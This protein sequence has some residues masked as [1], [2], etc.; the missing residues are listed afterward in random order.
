MAS[1]FNLSRNTVLYAAT[2]DGT[3]AGKSET[4]AYSTTNA[5]RI[6]VLDGYAFSQDVET[7]V[8]GLNEAG[9]RPV[10]GQKI[11][12]TALNPVDVSFTTYMRPFDNAASHD[13]I[14]RV[15]WEAIATGPS[16]GTNKS[17]TDVFA[18]DNSAT[19]SDTN[20]LRVDF[21][22]SNVHELLHLYL[23]FEL[24]NGKGFR[25]DKVILNTA[26]I[27]FSIDD[28]A[29]VTW[30]GQG[31]S[32][33]E[34]S[35]TTVAADWPTSTFFTDDNASGLFIK[36]KLST[37][38][39]ADLGDLENN[40]ATPV[41]HGISDVTYATPLNAAD[42][43]GLS[44]TTDSFGL[45]LDT[46]GINQVVV[47]SSLFDSWVVTKNDVLA[48]IN[49]LQGMEGA[50]IEIT[51][52][53]SIVVTSTS[54][55]GTAS[56]VALS[57][58][59]TTDFFAAFGTTPTIDAGAA[60]GSG[61]VKNYNVPITGGSLTIDNGVTFLVPEE[62]GVVNQT[63]GSFSGTRAITGNVTAYLR[64]GSGATQGLL[65]D[66]INATDAITTEFDM[67]LAIGGGANIPRVE[68]AM[69]HAHLVIPA[70]NTEDVIAVDI[71]IT[72]LGLDI[73]KNN[74]LNVK[75]YAT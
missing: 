17:N 45:N 67:T 49:G 75:Y 26:E 57:A 62:L 18:A 9:A 64:S 41:T 19:D 7:Q 38:T 23:H 25:V 1:T 44:V 14:E 53:G 35:D 10:R 12:N 63:I 29:K 72:G 68:L 40:G 13:A 46:G 5:F 20:R 8:I 3:G 6:N 37:M 31:E 27:D 50:Q 65:N 16:V 55:A 28:I 61:V 34:I 60:A 43:H 51:A 4:I 59:T 70:V 56:T 33:T 71:G 54:S 52:D 73:E 11:F 42:A 15:L 39:L 66:F 74:E 30:S 21:E 24:D 36:N 48:Y 47:N 2:T 69:P 32:L 22:G 58:G